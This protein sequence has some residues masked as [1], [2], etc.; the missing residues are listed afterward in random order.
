MGIGT[1]TLDSL[2]NEITP[3]RRNENE[4][5]QRSLSTT[6]PQPVIYLANESMD[7][8]PT[9]TPANELPTRRRPR[10]QFSL[11]TL[12]IMTLA[13]SCVMAWIAAERKCEKYQANIIAL[14]QL[15]GVV[16]IGEQRFARP[17]WLQMI[18][19]DDSFRNITSVTLYSTP[20]TDAALK[21]LHG[22]TPLNELQLH[23]TQI[24]DAGLEH[25]KSRTALK[26][27][28]LD[29]A[30]ITDAGLVHLKGFKAIKMLSLNDTQV[31]NSGLEQI[32]DLSHLQY[33]HLEN[34]QITDVGLGHLKGLSN[35]IRLNLS[36]TQVTD[37]GLVHPQGF[38]AAPS[39]AT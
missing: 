17:G 8:Q 32:T 22:L 16:V 3:N 5:K 10:L 1:D 9:I 28:S 12:L 6:K 19:G 35:L 38:P 4:N 34:T 11:R 30:K 36:Y 21:Y 33:L 13:F 31:T 24:T 23:K 14:R 29:G 27:L 37:A 26:A 15:R 7:N 18:L 25:L 39:S 20:V 2:A